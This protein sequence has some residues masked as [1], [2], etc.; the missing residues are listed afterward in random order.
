MPKITNN[1]LNQVIPTR[2]NEKD[3]E[4]L[5]NLAKAPELNLT[6]FSG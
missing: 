5:V 1:P 3:Y 2:L 6:F 4:E